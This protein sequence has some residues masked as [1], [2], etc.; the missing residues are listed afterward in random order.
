MYSSEK[1][2][3]FQGYIIAVRELLGDF[4]N[5][6]EIPRKEP[7]P[8]VFRWNFLSMSVYSEELSDELVVLGVSSEI[9]FLGVSSEMNFRGVI[10]E[11]L[12]RRSE[13]DLLRSETD[14]RKTV[15][16]E[17]QAEND[18]ELLLVANAVASGRERELDRMQAELRL[19]TS[20]TN[21]GRLGTELDSRS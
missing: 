16:L 2:D 15:P 11:D 8:S 14:G 5:S 19:R 1:T 7:L 9:R 21:K 18:R 12:F 4:K 20:D 6:E 10:S 17:S 3:E 13:P